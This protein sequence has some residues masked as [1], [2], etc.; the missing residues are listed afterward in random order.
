M[1]AL[2][3]DDIDL[4]APIDWDIIKTFYQNDAQVNL[5][6]DKYKTRR[7]SGRLAS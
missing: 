2:N 7:R 5:A 3:M 1:E 4:V 6:V